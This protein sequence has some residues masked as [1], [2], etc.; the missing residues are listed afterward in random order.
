MSHDNTLDRTLDRTRARRGFARV[1]API[2]LTIGVV[3]TAAAC[4]SASTAPTAPGSAQ[5]STVQHTPSAGGQQSG[6]SSSAGTSPQVEVHPPGDIPDSQAFVPYRGSSYTVSV[7]E[8]WGRTTA[9]NAVVF[10][11]KYNSITVI[12]R[13][14]APRLT[15]SRARSTE[16]AAI[17]AQAKGFV[18]GTVTTVHRNAGTAV[19]IT[20]RALSAVNPVTGKVARE[21][22]E[23]YEFWRNG[24]EVALVLSAPVGSDNV[25]PWRTVTN[26]FAWR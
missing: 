24:T 7:P 18:P 17:K 9:P 12:S 25:D 5:P 1:V 20:Y 4:S 11:D 14:G 21:A 10:R 22:V 2:V 15:V 8:G 6:T 3:S 16:V 19:L 23:R 13:S 26:S